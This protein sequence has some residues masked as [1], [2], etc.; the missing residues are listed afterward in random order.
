MEDNFKASVHESADPGLFKSIFKKNLIATIS[1]H[2]TGRILMVND[3]ACQIFGYSRLEFQKLSRQDILIPNDAA[4]A[5]LAKRDHNGHGHGIIQF[6]RKNGAVFDAYATAELFAGEPGNTITNVLIIDLTEFSRIE[7]KAFE[8]MNMFKNVLDC[9][10]DMISII[11][12][13]WK[14]KF[15]S[16]STSS[17]TGYSKNELMSMHPFAIVHPDDQRQA[18]EHLRQIT[19]RST[20]Q[21]FV[22][23]VIHKSGA[24]LTME[25]MANYD[26]ATKDI[27]TIAKD[28][29]GNAKRLKQLIDEESRFRIFVEFAS[30][31]ILVHDF[32]GTIL[33]VN[34]QTCANLGYSRETLLTL[35]I[36]DIDIDFDIEKA[37]NVWSRV[38]PES[39][40]IFNGTHL[41]KDGTVFPVEIHLTSYQLNRQTRYLALIRDITARK[42]EQAR[43]MKINTDL[44]IKLA[45]LLI[46]N[47]ELER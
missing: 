33:D 32:D 10:N 17:L 46:R 14:F 20:V 24:I 11:G 21:K 12:A 7:E 47:Q 8:Q 27:I 31:A 42:A 28:I 16:A 23:R 25:V 19:Y 1:A 29:T 43:L 41:R 35:N 5:L 45:R 3:A 22:H 15:L 30:D 9:A 37:Q 18:E 4:M 26:E 39:P 13:D 44:K 36:V 34:H 6:R 40:V 38:S 2:G